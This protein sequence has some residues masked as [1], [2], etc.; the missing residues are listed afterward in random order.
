MFPAGKEI[1]TNKVK[2]FL[3]HPDRYFRTGPDQGGP[4]LR[5][6]LDVD[7]SEDELISGGRITRRDPSALPDDFVEAAYFSGIE[8]NGLSALNG[9]Q[10]QSFDFGATDNNDLSNVLAQVDPSVSSF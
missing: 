1:A 6:D 4:N 3:K 10:N 5:T 9:V 8:L 2:D 7:S